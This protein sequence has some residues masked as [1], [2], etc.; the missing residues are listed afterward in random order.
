MSANSVSHRLDSISYFFIIIIISLRIRQ[1]RE[2][3]SHAQAGEELSYFHSQSFIAQTQTHKTVPSLEEVTSLLASSSYCPT[4]LAEPSES[5]YPSTSAQPP[6]APPVEAKKPNLIPVYIDLPTDFLTP[7]AAY[8]KIASQSRYSF[9][10]E[11]VV[12]G[13]SLAR[14]S[15]VGAGTC[16]Q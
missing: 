8:L 13:E 4:T 11:S 2:T 10:L 6:I 5:T 14:Y 9:L 3:R 16:L 1:R 7:V 15:F 12:G